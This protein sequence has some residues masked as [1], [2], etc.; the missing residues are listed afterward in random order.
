MS[1]E[2]EMTLEEQREN[3]KSE[4]EA[5]ISGAAQTQKE[6]LDLIQAARK[7]YKTVSS[8][9]TATFY[10]RLD[11]V[12]AQFHQRV[13]D[14]NLP[15]PLPEAYQDADYADCWCYAFEISNTEIKLLL[16]L[17]SWNFGEGEP[18]SDFIE[19][20]TL[21][22]IPHKLLTVSAY[23]KLYGLD[24]A[25]VQEEIEQGKIS[26]AVKRKNKWYVSEL[27]HPVGKFKHIPMVWM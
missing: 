15:Q 1:D 16:A 27:A 20:F 5:G 18:Y 19:T 17:N 4:V 9:D 10:K 26:G 25:A 2:M 6:L 23:A 13:R 8:S 12:L 22:E 14:I 7:H 11:G 24:V 21:I 3:W